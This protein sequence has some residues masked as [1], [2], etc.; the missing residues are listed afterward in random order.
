MNL[1][2]RTSCVG[3]EAELNVSTIFVANKILRLLISRHF[4]SNL[5]GWYFYNAID[6]LLSKQEAFCIFTQISHI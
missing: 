4:I 1:F 3:S 2:C 5:S 6:N